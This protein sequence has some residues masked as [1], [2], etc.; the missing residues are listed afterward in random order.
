MVPKFA[1]PLCRSVREIEFIMVKQGAEKERARSS[2]RG[3]RQRG[4]TYILYCECSPVNKPQFVTFIHYKECGLLCLLL[5]GTQVRA[6]LFLYLQG[7]SMRGTYTC[8]HTHIVRFALG[9]VRNQLSIKAPHV[10]GYVKICT[11]GKESLS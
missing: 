2:G 5:E 3:V 8:A 7:I 1:P 10:P 9:D 6:S 4:V 11:K